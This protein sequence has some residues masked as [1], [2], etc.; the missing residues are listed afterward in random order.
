MS[1]WCIPQSRQAPHKVDRGE[2]HAEVEK[3][4]RGFKELSQ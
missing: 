2:D 3:K 4:D 1:S